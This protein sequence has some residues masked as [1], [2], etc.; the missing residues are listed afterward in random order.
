MPQRKRLLASM[1]TTRNGEDGGFLFYA[2][3][4]LRCL[5][6]SPNFARQICGGLSFK[7]DQSQSVTPAP[8]YSKLT[9]IG[10]ELRNILLLE[11]YLPGRS[12]LLD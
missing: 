5:T 4:G 9:P 12:E 11:F 6:S 8:W 1:F 3:T 2:T 7:Y 10:R